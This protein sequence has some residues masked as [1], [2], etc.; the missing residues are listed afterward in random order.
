M[1]TDSLIP[2]VRYALI[3]MLPNRHNT[4][5]SALRHLGYQVLIYTLL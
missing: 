2:P 4:K 3:N 1:S 5:D